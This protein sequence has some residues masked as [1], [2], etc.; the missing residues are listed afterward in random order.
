MGKDEEHKEVPFPAYAKFLVGGVSGMVA[1]YAVHPMDFLKTRLQMSGSGGQKKMYSG[2]LDALSKITK[3]E[4][5]MAVFNGGTACIGRQIIYATCRLGIYTTLLGMAQK[6]DEPPGFA[7]KAGCGMA[8]GLIAG[9]FATPMDLCIIRMISDGAKPP[10][11]QFKYHHVVNCLMRIGKEEGGI[12][13]LYRGAFPT[14]CRAMVV[15]GSVLATYSQA[16][17]FLMGIGQK[18]GLGL[19]SCASIIAGAVT[20]IV[21]L[22]VDIIKTRIQASKG[23]GNPLVIVGGII[24]NEGPFAFWKGLSP[25]FVRLAPMTILTFIFVEKFTYWYHIY[26]LGNKNPKS[27]L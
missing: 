18:E 3:A 12:H 16:K 5:V 19:H 6:G 13:G 4:G 23:A 24:K 10:D 20:A 14:T 15:N 2:P 27:N 9:F 26:V 7:I 17:E 1:S 25:Y 22:P 11:K 8:S 21:S